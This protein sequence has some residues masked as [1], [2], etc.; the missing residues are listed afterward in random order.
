MPPLLPF[1]PNAKCPK[2]GHDQT[3]DRWK[4]AKPGHSYIQEHHGAKEWIGR[5]CQRCSYIWDEACL[6]AES[7]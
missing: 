4:V 1:N 6:D 7:V 2:C 3:D 5:R